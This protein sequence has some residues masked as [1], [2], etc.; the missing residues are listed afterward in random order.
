MLAIVRKELADSFNSARFFVLFLLMLGGS[1]YSLYEVRQ[2]IATIISQNVAITNTGYVFLAMFTY[3]PDL[4]FTQGT[5]V[6]LTPLSILIPILGISLGF[7][8]INSE[9]QSRT[10]SRV[11]AQPVYRDGVISGKFVAGLIVM[12]MMIGT[13]LLLIAGFGIKMIG[14]APTDEEIIRLFLYF[15]ISVVYG[16]F[17]MGLSMLCSV[18]FKRAAGSLLVPLV[19]F[20][21]LFTWIFIAPKLAPVTASTLEG[22]IKSVET[23][24]ALLRIS[25][26]Y[27]YQESFLVLLNPVP[28]GLGVMTNNAAQ[29]LTGIPLSL[30]E[31]L[32]Q[33]WPRV[34]GLVA[35]MAIFFAL[36]YIV[37]IKQEVRAT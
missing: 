20:I 6:L 9:R 3:V 19:I 14:I 25:P 13:S 16:A 24:F 21:A 32:L 28:Y 29:F 17:W 36:G 37:F 8:A 1:A 34:V 31:S 11:L 35:L 2:L 18:L 15:F 12:A 33:I 23:Q 22:Q 7:D 4:S 30:G 27:L 5:A 26:A 10:M